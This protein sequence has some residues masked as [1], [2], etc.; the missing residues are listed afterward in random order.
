MSRIFENSILAQQEMIDLQKKMAAF[1]CL[2]DMEVG[3]LIVLGKEKKI[4][5]LDSDDYYVHEYLMQESIKWIYE[6]E[7]VDAK[8]KEI[9]KQCDIKIE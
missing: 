1:V 8:T 7:D 6:I 5:A 2:L 4:V 9:L 3:E